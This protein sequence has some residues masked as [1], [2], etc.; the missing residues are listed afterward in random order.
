MKYSN[1]DMLREII[2][3]Q[4]QDHPTGCGDSF[5]E[6]LCYELHSAEEGRGRTFLQV[7]EKWGISPTMLGKLIADHCERLEP[8]PCVDHINYPN[9]NQ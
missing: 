8:L 6:I 7:A 5:D 1:I 9:T 2:R 4:Y 3:S